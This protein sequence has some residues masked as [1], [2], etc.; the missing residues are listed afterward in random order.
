MSGCW[1]FRAQDARVQMTM[2]KGKPRRI[3]FCAP[4]ALVLSQLPHTPMPTALTWIIKD[5]RN[6]LQLEG[7]PSC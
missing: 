4:K 6:I 3:S 2:E 1:L 5:L 7:E